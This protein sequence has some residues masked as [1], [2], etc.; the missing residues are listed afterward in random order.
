MQTGFLSSGTVWYSTQLKIEPDIIVY[1]KKSQVSG[2]M[3]KKSHSKVFENQKRL[4]VTYD[5]DLV[6]MIRCKYIINTIDDDQLKKNV[7]TMI[8]PTRKGASS[9]KNWTIRKF[10]SF[11][12][13]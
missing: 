9:K 7:N 6:D 2:I 4:S 1:G 5:G 8:K 11:N 13:W 12:K 10:I 3:V